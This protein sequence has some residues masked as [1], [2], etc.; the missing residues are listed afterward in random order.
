MAEAEADRTSKRAAEAEA[1]SSS[2]QPPPWRV[3]SGVSCGGSGGSA[4]EGEG[5]EEKLST[6][7]WEYRQDLSPDV[8]F[9]DLACVITRNSR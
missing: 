1:D 9:M 5:D 3:L 4:A 6:L 2:R 8:N 7:G